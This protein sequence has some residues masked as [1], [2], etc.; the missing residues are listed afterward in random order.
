MKKI[1]ISILSALVGGVAGAAVGAGAV[2]K[3]T[4]ETEDKTKALADK[5]LNLFLLMNQWVKVKQE[6]KSIADYLK[7]SGYKKIAIYG[8][9]YVAETLIEE[10]QNTEIEVAYGIDKNG[11]GICSADI[12]ICS[13]DE[14]LGEVDAVIVTAITFFDEIEEELSSRMNCPI[15]SLEDVLYDI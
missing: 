2:I 10:L 5:H 12:D 3:A 13:M 4:G 14:E 15:I 7:K 6:G 1:V 9:S 8:I 11:G